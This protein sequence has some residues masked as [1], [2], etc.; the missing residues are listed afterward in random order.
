MIEKREKRKIFYVPG[1]ISLVLIPLFCF[2]HFYK[3][4]AFKV[5]GSLDFSVPNK[6]DF[7]KYKVADLRKYKVFDFNEKKSKELRKLNELKFFARDLVKRYDSVNGAK[8]HFGS[9]TDYGTF[10]GVINILYE[11]KV[12]TWGLFSD[13]LYVMGN[14]KPKPR[15][16]G[17]ICGT[18]IYSKENTLRIQEE[19]R[20][21]ELQIFQIHFLKQ[22]WI[23]FLGI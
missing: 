16:S 6:G 21:K 17:F 2:Y 15:E 22:Q 4:D 7:E 14:R 8:I 10:I 3:V 18:G 5:Y 12:P 11:E 9:T 13:N 19:N 23:I 20:K 1:M